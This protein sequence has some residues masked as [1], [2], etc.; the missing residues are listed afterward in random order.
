MITKS[1]EKFIYPHI[2]LLGMVA[3][4]MVVTGLLLGLMVVIAGCSSGNVMTG[5]SAAVDGLDDGQRI[6]ERYTIQNQT[7]GGRSNILTTHIG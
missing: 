5:S 7:A 2:L 1:R 6:Q 3:K 4:K